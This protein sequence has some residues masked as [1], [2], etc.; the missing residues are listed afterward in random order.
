[1]ILFHITKF[2]ILFT[3]FTKTILIGKKYYQLMSEED[4]KPDE[5]SVKTEASSVKEPTSTKILLIVAIVLGVVIVGFLFYFIQT[6][7]NEKL[8]QSTTTTE[9]PTTT[10]AI[11]YPIS[12]VPELKNINESK[13]KI[14]SVNPDLIFD[15]VNWNATY[16]HRFNLPGNLTE[17]YNFHEN[18]GKY[19]LAFIDESS[20]SIWLPWLTDG[21][22]YYEG[23]LEGKYSPRKGIVIMHPPGIKLTKSL[24]QN[25]TLPEKPVLVAE[26]ASLADW[27]QPCPNSCSDAIVKIKIDS[28]LSEY[29]LYEDIVN[30][31]L[32]WKTVM[33]NISKYGNKEVSFKLEANT[34]GPCSQWC[35]EWVS[36]NKFY[37][38]VLQD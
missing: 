29:T 14:V 15:K 20:K 10:T 33:L 13:M 22:I 36:V 9:Y 27:I 35:A 12:Y 21:G 3:K 16:V 24:V 23:P 6:K 2:N 4:S 26:F 30:S 19:P 34:G 11:E 18:K 32:N 31:S 8:M 37:V 7:S 25:I 5:Q 17:Q 38:G 1:M 28:D